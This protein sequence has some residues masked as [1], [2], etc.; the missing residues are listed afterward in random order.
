[1]LSGNIP[2]R[3]GDLRMVQQGRDGRRRVQMIQVGGKTRS[4]AEE[5]LSW[6]M[7]HCHRRLR[8]KEWVHDCR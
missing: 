7:R 1:M 3:M 6:M 4:V 5:M 2:G 8:T